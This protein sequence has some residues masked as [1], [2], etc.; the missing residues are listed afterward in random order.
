MSPGNNFNVNKVGTEAIQA[1]NLAHS[2]VT[3]FT[4]NII[5][6]RVATRSRSVE[7]EIR[8]YEERLVSPINDN[9]AQEDY[10][11]QS[12]FSESTTCFR[13]QSVKVKL[14][15]CGVVL[16]IAVI[17]GITVYIQTTSTESELGKLLMVP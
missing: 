10:E 7:Q 4:F 1:V 17:I 3:H 15:I 2:T 8:A 14:L 16:I 6:P 13:K 12:S 9:A 5:T 11:N